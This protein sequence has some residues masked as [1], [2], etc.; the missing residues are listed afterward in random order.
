MKN[1]LVALAVSAISL[2]ATAGDFVIKTGSEGGGYFKAGSRVGHSISAEQVK[3]NKKLNKKGKEPVDFDIEVE[4]SNGSIENIQAFND[5]DAQGIMVQ[6]DALNLEKPSFKY[7]VRTSHTE[8]VLWIYNKEHG[9]EDLSDV[10]GRKDFAVVIVEGS[11]GN[12]TFN[13]F[14]MEDDGYA[15][16]PTVEA[17]DLEDALDIVAEGEY[18]GVKVAGMIHVSN[19]LPRDTVADYANFVQV[20]EATDGDFNDATDVEG[21]K[22][23]TNCSIDLKRMGGLKA[24]TWTNPDTV[25]VKSVFAWNTQDL[26]RN[27][28]KVV[29]KAAR[30]VFVKVN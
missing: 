24:S 10:E 20:G 29:S 12:V 3:M 13:S 28:Q 8:P 21:N 2:S 9:Y 30:K 27:E 7:K 6:V 25:C 11:G 17:M 4:T 1:I 16:N 26:S 14:I 19:T 23:Y 22:L 18:E 5:G 15:K